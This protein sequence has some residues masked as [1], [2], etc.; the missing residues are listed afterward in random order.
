MH[1]N[2]VLTC[3][4]FVFTYPLQSCLDGSS[5][6]KSPTR[7]LGSHLQSLTALTKSFRMVSD[8]NHPQIDAI[9]GHFC[10]GCL[11]SLEPQTL[12][13]HL[14]RQE[15]RR[16]NVR[17]WRRPSK[18]GKLFGERNCLEKY[19]WWSY[20]PKIVHMIVIMPCNDPIA[21]WERNWILENGIVWVQNDLMNN[22][23]VNN[24]SMV[25]NFQ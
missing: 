14:R 24:D 3:V 21:L 20:D 7:L 8:S 22:S 11:E 19:P 9:N 25:N 17:S 5:I 10:F 1:L 13:H 2:T 6:L 18:K 4:F 23:M 15:I 16:R 12:G